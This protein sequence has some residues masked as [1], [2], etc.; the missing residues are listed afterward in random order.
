M[1]SGWTYLAGAGVSMPSGLPT[2]GDIAGRA[3]DLLVDAPEVI[4]DPRLVVNCIIA[5]QFLR[6]R[7]LINMGRTADPAL[8]K[9]LV[10]KRSKF[11]RLAGPL[12][13]TFAKY[14]IAGARASN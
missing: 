9:K 11:I 13:H 3:F 14:E 6:L 4:P 12:D 7:L 8:F 5:A 1:A 10:K 2:G